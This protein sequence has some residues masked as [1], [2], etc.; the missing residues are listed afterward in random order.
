MTLKRVSNVPAWTA[1]PRAPKTITVLK[2]VQ[3]LA[4]P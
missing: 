3:A 1:I 2:A 4:I